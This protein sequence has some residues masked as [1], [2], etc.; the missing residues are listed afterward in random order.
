M[1]IFSCWEISWCMC[2]SIS[3]IVL[4][5][6]WQLIKTVTSLSSLDTLCCTFCC[7][8]LS[9]SRTIF[10]AEGW[11]LII[12][13]NKTKQRKKRSTVNL[14]GK[15]SLRF[16]CMLENIINCVMTFLV[17][18]LSVW[19]SIR[20]KYI[21]VWSYTMKPLFI[22]ELVE[23]DVVFEGKPEWIF[24]WGLIGKLFLFDVL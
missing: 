11:H 18:Y 13:S 2:V 9:L 19:L 5:N 1:N 16:Y 23:N 21:L 17:L 14:H 6:K 15:P 12:K 22:W 4:H 10:L 7:R 3:F 20:S 8:L 24:L